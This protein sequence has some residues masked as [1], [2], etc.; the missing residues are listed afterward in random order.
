MSPRD[1]LTEAEIAAVRK[2]LADENA[3]TPRDVIAKA[4]SDAYETRHL[5]TDIWLEMADA[6]IDALEKMKVTDLMHARV[7]W[8]MS[9]DETVTELWRAMVGAMRDD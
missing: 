8:W 9:S 7:E 5:K 1:E 3:L 6:V 4:I 2:A